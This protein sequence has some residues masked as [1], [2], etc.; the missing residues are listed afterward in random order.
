[1]FLTTGCMSKEC[2][3]LV[4]RAADIIAR[5][6]KERYCDVVRHVRTMIRFE[7]LRTIL[8]ALHGYRGR[9]MNE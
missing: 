7:M 6:R 1:M 5:K 8:I 3:R 9:K 4:N 2:K